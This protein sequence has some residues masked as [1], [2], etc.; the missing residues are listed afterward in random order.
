M[1]PDLVLPEI[2]KFFCVQTIALSV[3]PPYY[4]VAYPISQCLC[5]QNNFSNK[6]GLTETIIIC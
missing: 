2:S 3:L 6:T 5:E 1:L 4:F